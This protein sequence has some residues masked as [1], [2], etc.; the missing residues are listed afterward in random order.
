MSQLV[1]SISGDNNL[2]L[3]HLWLREAMVKGEKLSTYFMLGYLEN[4]LLFSIALRMQ[5]NPQNDLAL[6]DKLH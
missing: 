1:Y 2:L 5:E 4:F 3:Y 6:E